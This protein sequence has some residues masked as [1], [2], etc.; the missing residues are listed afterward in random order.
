MADTERA[1]PNSDREASRRSVWRRQ[2]QLDVVGWM[3]DSANRMERNH[4]DR[5]GDT[6]RFMAGAMHALRDLADRIE[7]GNE[8]T[9]ALREAAEAVDG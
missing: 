1:L 5:T 6:E 7:M 8:A 2:G 4:H 9:D 3:R